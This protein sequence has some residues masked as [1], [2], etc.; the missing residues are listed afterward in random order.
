MAIW[1]ENKISVLRTKDCS[2]DQYILITTNQFI[3]G[4][5]YFNVKACQNLQE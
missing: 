2:R 3:Q 5:T 4:F 1:K